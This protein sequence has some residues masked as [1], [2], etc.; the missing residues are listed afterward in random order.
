MANEGLLPTHRAPLVAKCR[1]RDKC[2][3]NETH[4]VANQKPGQCAELF[5]GGLTREI[6]DDTCFLHCKSRL[7]PFRAY[8]IRSVVVY[9][10]VKGQ[11]RAPFADAEPILAVRYL[12]PHQFTRTPCT[13]SDP[14]DTCPKTNISTAIQMQ[15]KLSWSHL[16]RS[17]CT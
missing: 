7:Q 3:Q 5:T 15:T 12:I 6:S 10:V 2:N 4:S 8:P 1:M 11:H 17:I 16:W 13:N 9:V 14:S